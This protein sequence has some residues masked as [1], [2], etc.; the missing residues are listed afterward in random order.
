MTIEVENTRIK[1][2]FPI[3]INAVIAITFTYLRNQ[4][5]NVYLVDPESEIMLL[6]PGKDYYIDEFKNLRFYPNPPSATGIDDFTDHNLIIE[7]S[8]IIDQPTVWSKFAPQDM[9][10]IEKE[11]DKMTMILQELSRDYNNGRMYNPWKDL[12]VTGKQYNQYDV[13]AYYAGYTDLYQ[14]NVAHISGDP[15]DDLNAGKWTQVHWGFVS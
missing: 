3:D 10:S 9:E 2:A 15:G 5:V 12:W 4:D 13:V 6:V 11:L 7:R 14:C 8:T 1:L